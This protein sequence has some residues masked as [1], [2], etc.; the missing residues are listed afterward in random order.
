V[1]VAQRDRV[2]KESQGEHTMT[3]GRARHVGAQNPQPGHMVEAKVD[4]LFEIRPKRRFFFFFSIF[5]IQK[6]QSRFK[7][8]V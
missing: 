2:V 5:Q 7:L 1:P 6:I 8:L 4:R 3:D